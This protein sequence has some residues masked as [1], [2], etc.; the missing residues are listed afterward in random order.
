[1]AVKIDDNVK[2][3]V[4]TILRRGNDAVIRKKGDGVVV[5]EEK[6]KIVYSPSPKGE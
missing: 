6:R 4:E 2:T 1:M 5:L 3:A